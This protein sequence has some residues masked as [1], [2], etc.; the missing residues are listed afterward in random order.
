MDTRPQESRKGPPAQGHALGGGAAVLHGPHERPPLPRPR[1]ALHPAL[2]LRGGPWPLPTPAPTPQPL[3]LGAD[4]QLLPAAAL[5][6][7]EGRREAAGAC[8]GRSQEKS[9]SVR[10]E[11][12]QGGPVEA[13]QAGAE[14]RLT[15]QAANAAGPKEQARDHAAGLLR[16]R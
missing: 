10:V 4:D 8:Q 14:R 3:Q 16:E 6:A 2:A 5:R 13:H 15:A 12:T 7:A 11:G 9:V 1:P